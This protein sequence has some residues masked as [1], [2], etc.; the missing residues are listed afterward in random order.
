MGLQFLQ[1]LAACIGQGG[2]LVNLVP[3][4]A[5]AQGPRKSGVRE[6]TAALSVIQV[7]KVRFAAG[8]RPCVNC[9]ARGDVV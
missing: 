5:V 9:K 8:Q 2:R 7:K 6:A 1:L 3:R 4:R